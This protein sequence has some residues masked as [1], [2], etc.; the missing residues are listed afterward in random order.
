MSVLAGIFKGRER[1]KELK[2]T[3]ATDWGLHQPTTWKPYS[4]I[5]LCCTNKSKSE[6]ISGLFNSKRRLSPK[7]VAWQV[8]YLPIWFVGSPDDLDGF[9]QWLFV[10]CGN[11]FTCGLDAEQPYTLESEF[12]PG[13]E[14]WLSFPQDNPVWADSSFKQTSS[15]CYTTALVARAVLVFWN[16]FFQEKHWFKLIGLELTHL[17]IW[18]LERSEAKIRINRKSL[19]QGWFLLKQTK[20]SNSQKL[21]EIKSAIICARVGSKKVFQTFNN[22]FSMILQGVHC[23][24]S[25]IMRSNG[26]YSSKPK[27]HCSFVICTFCPWSHGKALRLQTNSKHWLWCDISTWLPSQWLL[28]EPLFSMTAIHKKWQ[29]QSTYFPSRFLSPTRLASASQNGTMV[30]PKHSRI[31]QNCCDPFTRNNFPMS[32]TLVAINA[33]CFSLGVVW[34]LCS[35][36]TTPIKKTSLSLKKLFSHV[37]LSLYSSFKHF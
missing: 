26:D 29:Q 31:F 32:M 37:P 8:L 21:F 7:P 27:M 28:L 33:L 14:P 5:S 24:I 1:K 10:G 30:F 6:E 23:P 18:R 34:N 11:S 36:S 13:F 3:L 25:T 15:L 2:P 22:G 16:F 9:L 4:C 35:T 17:R 12:T 20:H 19:T